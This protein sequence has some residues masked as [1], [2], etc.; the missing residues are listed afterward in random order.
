MADNTL[1]A[2]SEQTAL[3]HILRHHAGADGW[4]TLCRKDAG[5]WTQ[6]HY[7]I[8]EIESALSEQIGDDTYF[9]QQTFYKPE[10]KVENI[11]QLRAIYT[12]VDCH[13]VGYDVDW[14]IGSIMA[15]LV[16]EGRLPE[17]NVIVHSGRGLHLVW[18]LSPAPAKAIALWQAVERYFVA[19]LKIWGAD[20]KAT[21]AAR[22][23]RV[24][25]TVNSKNQ[26]VATVQY[27]HEVR[28]ELRDL[29]REYL[30]ELLE[31][32]KK[33]ERTARQVQI[34]RRLFNQRT[35]HWA[36]LQDLLELCKLRNWQM[37]GHREEVCFLYRYWKCNFLEDVEQAL[38]DTLD[39][40]IQFSEPLTEAEVRRATRSAETAFKSADKQYRYGNKRL[41]ELLEITDEEQT[42]LKTIIG[43]SEKL[44][45]HREREQKR[46]KEA[47]A[48]SRDK[49]LEQAEIRRQEALRL[50]ND[51]MSYRAIGERLGI[52][53][54]QVM[55][56]VQYSSN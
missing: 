34:D 2:I 16:D 3:E 11:R 13:L 39:L 38:E 31:K 23:L 45:R 43:R 26:S 49:Y 5:Q 51:G 20:A 9:S 32:P 46:R 18:W 14:T 10:R 53:R 50:R 7:R 1:A 24:A 22:V 30:P 27:R 36:R 33:G 19:Q 41:I 8:D 25:G 37:T 21:D 44:R 12:D 40:N 56:I 4:V 47:G 29:Q 54:T 52:S 48:V 55:R 6:R 28:Y 15:N 42:H 35:L 17:P